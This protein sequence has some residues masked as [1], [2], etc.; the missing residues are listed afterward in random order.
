MYT[1]MHMT[2]IPL[3]LIETFV[4]FGECQNLVKTAK[5]LNQTQPSASRQIDQFQKHFKKPLFKLLGR[6]KRLT[7]YGDQVYN[8]YKRS[9]LELHSLQ[10][11]IDAMSFQNQMQRLTL[12][13][14]SEI[15]KAFISP[16]SFKNPV[17][18]KSSTGA[19]IRQDMENSKLD[20]AVLQE[21]FITYNYFRKKLFAAEWC[22]VIPKA[23]AKNISSASQWFSL[24][25]DQPFGS[26]DKGFSATY[27][28]ALKKIPFNDFN[29]KFM[30]DDWRLIADKVEQQ[31]CW[32]IMPR[33]H[34][35]RDKV[36]NLSMDDYF[37]EASFYLYFKK[38]HAKNQDVQN[39]LSQLSEN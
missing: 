39:I 23:W 7:E 37:K 18:L 10:K 36:I 29:F 6:Q 34:A 9:V 11:N 2:S 22:L 31:A 24:V 38:E 32:S 14:R 15:L 27:P 20:I 8:Y 4:V 26:Y 35:P 25:K 13:G 16:L 30:T 1:F 19:Q 3:H 28:N 17:Y 5:V 33:H 21:N 12:A